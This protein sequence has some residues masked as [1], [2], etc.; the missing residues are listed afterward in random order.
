MFIKR[1][2]AVPDSDLNVAVNREEETIS[3]KLLEENAEL[4]EKLYLVEAE[5]EKVTNLEKQIEE[6]TREKEEFENLYVNERIKSKDLENQIGDLKSDL[7]KVRSEGMKSNQKFKVLEDEKTIVLDEIDNIKQ[8]NNVLNEELMTLAVDIESKK[9]EIL[10][11]KEDLVHIKDEP[12]N[13]KKKN[14]QVKSSQTEIEDAL[15]KS[16]VPNT[17][18]ERLS[19]ISYPCFYCGNLVTSEG[20]LTM[21]RTLCH[22]ELLKDHAPTVPFTCDLCD[23]EFSYSSDLEKHY[24]ANHLR[25]LPYRCDFCDFKLENLLDLQCH[26]RTF[27]RNKLP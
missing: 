23:D 16:S 22:N 5:L 25:T 7:V 18:E 2:N 8:E 9:R 3:K 15:S 19:F 4:K 24:T 12:E 26:I 20:D 14:H 10:K 21:H 6:A 11:L 13:D 1:F 17:R 27:H